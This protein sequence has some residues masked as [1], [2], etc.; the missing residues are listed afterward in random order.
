MSTPLWVVELAE[1]F[2]AEAGGPG[3]FPRDLRRPVLRALPLAIVLLPGLSIAEVRQWLEAS[4][5]GCFCPEADR[6]LRA[7]LVARSGGGFIF[8][9][10]TDAEDQQRFSLAHELAHFLR[11]YWQPRNRAAHRLGAQ[12]TEVFDGMRPARF[13]EQIA[14]LLA[15]LPLGLHVHLM[16]RGA[17]GVADEVVATVEEEAD[18]LAFELLAPAALVLRGQP[19][20]ADLISRLETEF[21][22]PALQAEEY[23]H[24]LCPPLADALL[25]RLALDRD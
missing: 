23:A 6:R 9:D 15:E 24:R 14:A 17:S 5:I 1:G 25:R 12:I 20:R 2:W 4:G 11:H 18:Q 13:E 16:G 3:P 8:L 22:L 21:G 7:C 10:G 19:S